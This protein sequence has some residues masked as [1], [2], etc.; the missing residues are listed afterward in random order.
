MLEGEHQ[1][2][3]FEKLQNIYSKHLEKVNFEVNV[4][5]GKLKE[6]EISK[7]ETESTILKVEKAKDDAVTEIEKH[8][9][10]TKHRLEDQLKIKLERLLN[11]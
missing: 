7:K 1:G 9:Q 2:H 8:F 11:H 3:Q 10:A 4:L 5:L 6:L